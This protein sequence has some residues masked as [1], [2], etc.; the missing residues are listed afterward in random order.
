MS[1][2]KLQAAIAHA[3]IT[4][5]RKAEELIST[6]KVTVNGERAH[7]GQRVNPTKDSITVNG[8]K[9]ESAQ[10]NL[11]YFLVNKPVGVVSTVKD[12]QGRKT[13]VSLIP[14][15]PVRVYPV[16]RLD[17][18]SQG[19]LLLTNDGALAQKLTHPSFEVPKT[20]QVHVSGKMTPKALN[21]LRR[22]VKLREGFTQPA[23]V[24]V[25]VK[26]PDETIFEIT[27]HEGRNRQV[28]RMCERVGYEVTQL[29]RVS[30]GPFT[31]DDLEEAPYKE[32]F[33]NSISLI[34]P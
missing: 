6:G 31:L 15:I 2:I 18:D 10:E 33:K 30:F 9:L 14:K 1:S 4:S 29:I 23:E 17:I 24:T 5:R 28:R 25:L 11:R 19:L 26:E 22:G 16:G 12:E 21:H 20:Y 32:I 27:I 7:I 3:G 13:V 34:F 8:K